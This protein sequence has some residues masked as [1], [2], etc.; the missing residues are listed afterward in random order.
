MGV[1]AARTGTSG[2]ER[3]THPS[4]HWLFSPE[5]RAGLVGCKI[6]G[7]GTKSHRAMPYLP[8]HHSPGVLWGVA[9]TKIPELFVVVVPVPPTCGDVTHGFAKLHQIWR[10]SGEFFAVNS[11]K[12]VESRYPLVNRRQFLCVVYRFECKIWGLRPISGSRRGYR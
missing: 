11:D 4:D 12:S 10:L 2:V 7:F 9:L 3:E 1:S 6:S 8:M 5:P